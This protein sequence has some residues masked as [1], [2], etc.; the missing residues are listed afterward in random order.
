MYAASKAF[1]NSF[2]RSLALELSGTGVCVSI[3]CPGITTTKFRARAGMK[4]KRSSFSLSAEAVARIAF[5][6][7]MKGRGMIVP[8]WYNRLYVSL[9][10][11]ILGIFTRWFNKRRGIAAETG[12]KA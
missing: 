5:K 12:N 7:L 10:S 2:S 3:L 1:L 6:G 9:P 4:E 8:G 11:S